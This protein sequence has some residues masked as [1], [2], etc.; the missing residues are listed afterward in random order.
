[1]KDRKRIEKAFEFDVAADRN[2]HTIDLEMKFS[3]RSRPRN[4]SRLYEDGL[5]TAFEDMH[6]L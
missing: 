2:A 5:L 1:V 4:H 3:R 6:Q